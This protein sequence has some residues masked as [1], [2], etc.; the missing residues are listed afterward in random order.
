[1]V[2][3]I[4]AEKFNVFGPAEIKP[5]C[6]PVQRAGKPQGE[7][8]KDLYSLLRGRDITKSSVDIGI[9][10]EFVDGT[11]DIALSHCTIGVLAPA[12]AGGHVCVPLDAFSSS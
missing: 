9:F 6:G 2:S 8:Q 7:E 10:Q 12:L 11:A 5:R 1:M 3:C 4:A